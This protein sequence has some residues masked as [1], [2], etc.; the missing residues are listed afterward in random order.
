VVYLNISDLMVSKK[1]YEK[2]GC[3]VFGG[4]IV[5]D[6]LIIKNE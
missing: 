5:S 6:Y 3:F 2:I 1:F 4:G